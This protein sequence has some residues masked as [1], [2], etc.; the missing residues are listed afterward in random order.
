MTSAAGPVVGRRLRSDGKSASARGHLDAVL[1][2]TVC[3]TRSAGGAQHRTGSNGRSAAM[4][5]SIR[6]NSARGT[7]TSAIWKVIERP[8]LPAAVAR[9]IPACAGNAS[10]T[11][12]LAGFSGGHSRVRRDVVNDPSI[13]RFQ[14][15]APEG[16]SVH[17]GGEDGGRLF[18]F[19]NKSHSFKGLSRNSGGEGGGRDGIAF[20]LAKMGP[21]AGG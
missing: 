15:P 12:Q 18:I 20:L 5:S 9:F 16:S 11:G 14:K 10:K 4:A 1:L 2:L 19:S 21:D 3:A 7:A 6:R 13:G 17:V 8:C